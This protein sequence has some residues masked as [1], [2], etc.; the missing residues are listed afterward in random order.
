MMDEMRGSE[1]GLQYT[2][3]AVHCSLT[4][5]FTAVI[6]SE[7]ENSCLCQPNRSTR[8]RGGSIL[9]NVS[10]TVAGIIAVMDCVPHFVA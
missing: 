1:E 8:Q 2:D 6:D 3:T 5:Q 9:F 4:H 7:D 10:P